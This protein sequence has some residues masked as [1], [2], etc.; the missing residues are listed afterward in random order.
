VPAAETV[1]SKMT[2]E[3]K[4]TLGGGNGGECYR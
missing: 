4:E 1:V 3:M 2:A